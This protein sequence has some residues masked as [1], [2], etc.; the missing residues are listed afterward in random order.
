MENPASVQALHCLEH[1]GH[2]NE[3]QWIST[4]I[5]N[6]ETICQMYSIF[7]EKTFNVL[8]SLKQKLF[9][10]AGRSKY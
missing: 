1:C 4:K 2:F 5:A 8:G 10:Q 7:G 9:I 6:S 3:T